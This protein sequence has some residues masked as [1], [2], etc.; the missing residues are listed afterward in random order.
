MLMMFFL[1]A[2]MSCVMSYINLDP[3][4]SCFFLI[5]SLLMIMPLIS[6]FLH[7]WFSYFIC[8][9]FLSGIFVILVY[10]SSLSK[11]NYSNTPFYL[12][13]GLLSVFVFYPFFYGIFNYVSIS[14]FYYD[15]YWSVFIWV[16]LIL[17]FFMNFTSYYLNFSGALR[18]L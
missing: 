13:G 11:V 8:L 15:V 18:K 10:F 9:L 17:I 4:K 3:M 12:I 14:N 5:F 16:I 1:L 2:V 6:F 7:V